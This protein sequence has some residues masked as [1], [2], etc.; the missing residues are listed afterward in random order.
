MHRARTALF[1]L[2]AVFALVVFAGCGGDDEETA[3]GQ[4]IVRLKL[5]HI[6]K[7]GSPVFN[8]AEKLA[9]DVKERTGGAVVITIF[10]SSQLG[11]QADLIEGLQIGAVD[12]TISSPAVMSALTPE[13]AVLDLPYI[14][15]N[16]KQAYA[17]L[18][19]EIGQKLYESSKRDHG[20]T[21]LSMWENGFR[22]TT[23]SKR[24]IKSPED[25]NGLKI[26]VPESQ[27]Y[28]EMM[29]AL[30]ANPTPMEF[31][32]LFT[33]LQTGAVDG[34]ENPI[35]QTYSSR[36]HEIQSFMTLD[37]HIYAT[38]PVL[39]RNKSLEKLTPDQQRILFS[40]CDE[41]RDWERAS[42][43]HSEKGMM[44][45]ME[46]AGM[47]ITALTDAEIALFQKAVAP[48]WSLFE[49]SIGKDII[50]MVANYRMEDSK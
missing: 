25:M 43:A 40:A 26:R 39:I 5:G 3:D 21:I 30:G 7:P 24:E 14:F 11:N 36:F 37:G 19:G 16:A 17:V 8:A 33:A 38:Q 45:E 2:V 32:E 50:D 29:K 46:K 44:E 49:K 15:S 22:H 28:L 4:K 10:G 18:D 9:A 20:Y 23:N 34:Q 47:K 35:S 12:M 31:G 48:V 1:A 6:V 13:I 42:V 27:I 41:A